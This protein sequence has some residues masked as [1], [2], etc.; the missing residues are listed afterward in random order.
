MYWGSGTAVGK[1]I[2]PP[3]PFHF[4]KM[5]LRCMH[6]LTGITHLFAQVSRLLLHP[7]CNR[8]FSDHDCQ[9]QLS[10]WS[11][12]FYADMSWH[13][14]AYHEV[15][16]R[17]IPSPAVR[18]S[19]R[20]TMNLWDMSSQRRPTRKLQWTTRSYL[21]THRAHCTFCYL[22]Y[23]VEFHQELFRLWIELT[24]NC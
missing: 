8:Q 13:Q 21:G 16:L 5:S 7:H 12:I 10:S 11:K 15:D 1:I 14:A 24:G 20:T 22:A 3:G 18:H 17:H 9:Q 2:S 4:S 19:L 6:A 23:S